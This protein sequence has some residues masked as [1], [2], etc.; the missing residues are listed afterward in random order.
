MH[1]MGPTRRIRY[2]FVA[3]AFTLFAGD[4]TH[5][6]IERK[7]CRASDGASVVYSVFGK[8]EPALLFI[9]GGMADRT[10]WDAQLRA[11]GKHY[12]VIAPDLAGHGESGFH[13]EKLTIAEFGAD[14]K[15]VADAE[16]LRHVVMFGNSL[17]G[18]VAVEAALLMPGRVVAVVGVDTFQSLEGLPPEQMRQYAEAFRADYAGN[19]NKMVKSLFHP[20]ADAA[21][22]ADAERRMLKTS[23]E[24]AY[25]LFQGLA[26]YTP[27]PSVRRLNVPLRAIN[28]DL[29]PT[30]VETIRKTFAD[31]DVIVMKHM[32]HYPML[33]RPDEFNTHVAEVVA[34]LSKK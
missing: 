29:Y 28:G 12:R 9:H 13:R 10:F 21:I 15:A 4:G 11:F 32:G 19:V 3:F 6:K 31:F 30:N 34:A 20:D 1:A 27:A 7:S 2:L 17:G 24:T 25:A 16:K 18:P 14:V 23:P 5:M 22:M 26:G 33:E 8:G